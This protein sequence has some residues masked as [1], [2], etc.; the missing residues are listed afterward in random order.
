M[1]NVTKKIVFTFLVLVLLKS[2]DALAFDGSFIIITD[3]GWIFSD[4]PAEMDEHGN[5][6]DRYGNIVVFEPIEH[7]I[8][9]FPDDEIFVVPEILPE[10]PGGRDSL[11]RHIV[12]HRRMRHGSAIPEGIVFVTFVV[13]KDGSIT[14]PRILRGID[15][16]P[17][18]GADANAIHIIETMPNWIP[19]KHRGRAVRTQFNLPIRFTL[20]DVGWE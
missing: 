3:T 12:L 7:T 6:I 5:Q 1:S 14:N 11:M 19:G 16:L 9:T 8:D 17:E 2:S 15:P 13:E 4:C 18:I 10:F 20:R